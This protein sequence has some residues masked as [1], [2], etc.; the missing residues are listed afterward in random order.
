MLEEAPSHRW[1]DQNNQ[2]AAGDQTFPGDAERRSQNDDEGS[3]GVQ[4]ISSG[5]R[6][7]DHS[8]LAKMRQCVQTPPHTREQN[9]QSKHQT[10]FEDC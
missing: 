5:G 4:P 10:G 8:R 9:V 6:M 7:P 3:E 2:A 1:Y